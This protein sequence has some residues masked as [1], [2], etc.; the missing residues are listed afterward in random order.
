MVLDSLTPVVF[1]SKQNKNT[2]RLCV[3]LRGLP[4]NP[5]TVLNHASCSEFLL[6]CAHLTTPFKKA[7]RQAHPAR[8]ASLSEASIRRPTL[9][10]PFSLST[11]KC[12]EGDI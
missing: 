11:C 2:N 3:Y 7:R 9:V 6:G 1:P 4:A 12:A 8:L 5:F 10:A